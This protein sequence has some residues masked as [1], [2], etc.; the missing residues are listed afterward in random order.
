[1]KKHGSKRIGNNISIE[2]DFEYF[3]LGIVLGYGCF[4]IGLGHVSIKI[5]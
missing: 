4:A 2:Y 5:F 1:M 3:D